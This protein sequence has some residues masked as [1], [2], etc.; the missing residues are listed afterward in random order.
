MPEKMTI[1]EKLTTAIENV[2]TLKITTMVTG[3][4]A[5]QKM[6]TSI[7]LVQGDIKNSM[8]REFVTGDLKELRTFHEAQVLKGQRIIKDNIETLKALWT[9]VRDRAASKNG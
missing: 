2:V 7:D 5:S 1:E 6:E 9:F 4:G 8:D 3:G